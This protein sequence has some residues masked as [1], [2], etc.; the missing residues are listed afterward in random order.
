[1][2]DILQEEKENRH[3][4]KDSESNDDEKKLEPIMTGIMNTKEQITVCTF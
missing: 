2:A 3:K 1:M 4:N